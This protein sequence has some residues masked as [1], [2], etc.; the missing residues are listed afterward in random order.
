VFEPPN[1]AKL[2]RFAFALSRAALLYLIGEQEK[3]ND[4]PGV[5]MVPPL[6][7]PPRQSHFVFFRQPRLFRHW[8]PQTT[9]A[10]RRIA[11]DMQGLGHLRETPYALAIPTQRDLCSRDNRSHSIFVRSRSQ[12]YRIYAK[13]KELQAKMSKTQSLPRKRGFHSWDVGARS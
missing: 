2:A 12:K 3:E 11:A 8:V 13:I 10:P 5:V 6:R 7:Q 4:F 1:L 9:S